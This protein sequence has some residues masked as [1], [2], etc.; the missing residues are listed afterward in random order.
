MAQE[1]ATYPTLQ[2]DNDNA[3]SGPIIPP[4]SN[5]PTDPTCSTGPTAPPCTFTGTSVLSSGI[6]P[7]ATGAIFAVQIAATTAPGTYSFFCVIHPGMP[8]TLNVVPAGQPASPQATL[9]AQASSELNSL[10]AG[11]ASAEAAASVPKSTANANG[12][13]TWLVH[14]GIT[15]DDVE[16]LEYL[17]TNVPIKKGD[18]VKFDGSGTTQEP[19]TV[20]DLAA[21]GAGMFPFPNN[22]DCEVTTGPDTPAA[23]VNNGPP[24]T[25]CADPNGFEQPLNLTTQGVPSVISSVFDPA[26]AVVTGRPD[27]PAFS[28]ETSHTYQ[29]P[30]GGTYQF[31]CAFHQNMGGTVLTPGYRLA[32]NNGSLYNFGGAG[33]AG[34]HPGTA[35]PV[36]AVPAT[37]D[38][39]GYWLVTADGHTYNFGDAPAVGNLSVHLAAPIVGAAVGI[40]IGAQGPAM[41]LYL[42]A[43]D[44]GVFALGGLDYLGGM[45]GKHLNAPIVG[46]TTALTRPD[47][48][49]AMTSSPPTVACSASARTAT[50]TR[51]SSAAWAASTS[52]PRSSGSSTPLGATGTTWSPPM[53]GCSAS[54]RPRSRAAPAACTSTR[55]SPASPR[56][57]R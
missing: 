35:S 27:G 26:A 44:G 23:N 5:N 28:V 48:A 37:L 30:S 41:G 46:M 17:P 4:I 25:G 1:R 34:S 6:I 19:H 20:T 53:A 42:V 31:F 14:V 51:G 57:T 16:L 45:G 39:Q 40:N 10:N 43:K 50:A 52:T 36:V 54:A 55:P 24:E 9:A 3:E 15:A 47:P 29:F 21:A 33:F 8:G 22:N 32:S 56:A 12:S 49:G 11:A 2:A 18:S 13:H 7:N 38:N